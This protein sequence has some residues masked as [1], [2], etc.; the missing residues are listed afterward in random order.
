M[1]K[2]GKL[3]VLTFSILTL[4]F[5]WSCDPQRKEK[6]EW[7]FTPFPEGNSSVEEGWV[8][9]CVAN[10]KLGK[11]KCY[12]TSKLNFVNKMNG[13]PF[14]YSSLQFTNTFPKKVIS[15]KPC[16]GDR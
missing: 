12:F 1:N 9:L 7:Y 10:F 15:V 4:P 11:R 16:R 2:S 3:L 14:R 5:L 8:S 13:V 6:C